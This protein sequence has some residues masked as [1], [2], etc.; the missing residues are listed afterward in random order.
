MLFTGP[1]R[2]RR[3]R[4][5]GI[6]LSDPRGTIA[7]TNVRLISV[8]PSPIRSAKPYSVF[9]STTPDWKLGGAIA[10]TAG[11]DPAVFRASPL[12]RPSIAILADGLS[13]PG[14]PPGDLH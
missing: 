12:P 3:H 4:R 14:L 1:D 8:C 10:Y 5:V 2:R 9:A 11:V 13:V 6:D 7:F